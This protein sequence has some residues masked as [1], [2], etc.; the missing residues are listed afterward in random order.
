MDAEETNAV[1]VRRVRQVDP[2]TGCVHAGSTILQKETNVINVKNRVALV[3]IMRIVGDRG[4]GFVDAV[5]DTTFRQSTLVVVGGEP[6]CEEFTLQLPVFYL[7]S[8][9]AIIHRIYSI[10]Q[11]LYD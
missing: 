6:H 3:I 2:E 11:R 8:V 4:T 9:E 7:S 10:F 5:I 1:Q